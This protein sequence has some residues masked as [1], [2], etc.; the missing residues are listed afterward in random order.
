MS[1]LYYDRSCSRD[2]F[3]NR[4][5]SRARP[6]QEAR[7]RAL[8]RGRRYLRRK[9]LVTDTSEDNSVRFT[10]FFHADTEDRVKSRQRRTSLAAQ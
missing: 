8:N 5:F 10:H 9:Q 6:N 3:R 4:R 7:Y 2:T 1:T